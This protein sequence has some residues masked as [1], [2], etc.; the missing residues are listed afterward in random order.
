MN[1]APQYFPNPAAPNNVIAPFW[2]DLNPT[3]R[4]GAIRIGTLTDGSN[5]WIVVDWDR[6]K[7]FSNATTHTGEIW[8]QAR[9]RRRGTGPSSEQM[10]I[11]YGAANARPAGGPAAPAINW[12]AENRDGSSGENIPAPARPTTPEYVG[13]HVAADRGRLADDHLRRLEQEGGTYTRSARDDLGC[14]A[15][16]DPGRSRRS[17]SRSH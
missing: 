8:L 14:H 2:T 13:E 17:R 9:E 16:N 3:D 1:F 7:N 15:G 5:T 11:S 6:V 4:C 12:G 10:T